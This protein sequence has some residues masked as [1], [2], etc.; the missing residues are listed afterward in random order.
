MKNICEWENCKENGNF[1]SDDTYLLKHKELSKIKDFIYES[2]NKFT[3]ELW[4]SKQKVVITQSWC[5]K[6]L[7]N[8][9]H[10]VHHH[11]NSIVSGVFYFKQDATMPPIQFSRVDR[12]SLMLKTD[13]YNIGISS[14][15]L[16]ESSV[17]YSA[18]A[19]YNFRSQSAGFNLAYGGGF[20]FLM[21]NQSGGHRCL[22]TSQLQA[23]F[24]GLLQM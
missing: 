18:G 17:G 8:T 15:Q 6:N 19:D 21:H 24:W 3:T 14:T 10:P 2:L 23:S 12:Q 9:E 5:N 1:K 22:W 11:A 16:S 7:P 13:E 4:N 20:D